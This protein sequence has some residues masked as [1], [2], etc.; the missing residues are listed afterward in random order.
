MN[1]AELIPVAGQLI[2]LGI[3]LAD[4]IKKAEEIS[5][6]DKEAMRAMIKEA[7]DSVTYWTDEDGA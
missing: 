6:E 1:A 4:I 5:V 2:Q 3:K 7:K